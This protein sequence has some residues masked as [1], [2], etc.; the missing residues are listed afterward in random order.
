MVFVSITDNGEGISE[1]NLTKIFTHGFTTKA[2][3]HGFG[4][5]TCANLMTEM[6]G[7]LIAESDGPG[8]GSIFT[9][10]FPPRPVRPNP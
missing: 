4:L 9:L 10:V 8:C 7:R 2:D 3:G 6:N 1:E 5:H